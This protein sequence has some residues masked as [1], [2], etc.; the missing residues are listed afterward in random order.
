MFCY[1][2][3][4]LGGGGKWSMCSLVLGSNLFVLF[5]SSLVVGS[6]SK[7]VKSNNAISEVETSFVCSMEDI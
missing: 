2:G 7:L 1:I 4:F 5:S 3:G 6:H